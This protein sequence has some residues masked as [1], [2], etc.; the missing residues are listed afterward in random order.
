MEK[1]YRIKHTHLGY[2]LSLTNEWNTT[3][4]GDFART[5][6]LIEAVT[7]IEN[8]LEHDRGYWYVE[9][10]VETNNNEYKIGV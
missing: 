6:D 5:Y 1:K 10:V 7:F 3:P 4:N 9:P 8:L 2:L